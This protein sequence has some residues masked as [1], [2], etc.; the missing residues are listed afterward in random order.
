MDRK[1]TRE[2]DGK[3]ASELIARCE[4]ARR[5][6]TADMAAQGLFAKDGW[7][8]AEEVRSREGRT[9]L[10]FRPI[11]RVLPSPPGLECIVSIDQPGRVIESVC[12]S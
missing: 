10:F 7:R 3:L 5:Q 6:L 11:H 4:A 8:I 1:S 2:D 12:T 9:E